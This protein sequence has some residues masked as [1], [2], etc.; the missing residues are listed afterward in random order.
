[1]AVGPSDAGQPLFSRRT[2]NTA[3]PSLAGG[4]LGTLRASRP[5]VALRSIAARPPGS[6]QLHVD[7]DGSTLL[8][9][10]VNLLLIFGFTL[11]KG[12]D[13]L[14]LF[15][16]AFP[17]CRPKGVRVKADGFGEFLVRGVKIKVQFCSR[18]TATLQNN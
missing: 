5:P 12:F 17:F 2:D 16:E 9:L 3:R 8:C 11:E 6:A 18:I 10:D 1:V 15:L 14:D 4:T 13:V 7:G